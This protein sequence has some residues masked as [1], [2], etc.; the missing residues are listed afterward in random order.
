M[1]DDP[2]RQAHQRYMEARLKILDQQQRARDSLAAEE[3]RALM[4]S[5]RRLTEDYQPVSRELARRH[6]HEQ[7]LAASPRTTPADRAQFIVTNR[8]RF[9]VAQALGMREVARMI[10]SRASFAKALGRV[11]EYERATLNKR[12][13]REI[14][15]Q[16]EPI[17][18]T[19]QQRMEMLDREQEAERDRALGRYTLEA[20]DH[21][22]ALQYL[23]RDGLINALEAEPAPSREQSGLAP[24]FNEKGLYSPFFQKRSERIKVQMS[25]WRKAHME[26]ENDIERTR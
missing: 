24:S 11:H 22:A 25:D 15:Q 2:A 5:A 13:Q 7:R 1:N 9:S 17:Q 21:Q 8:Q 10:V 20:P 14:D 26:Q 4:S 3:R 6:G 12:V 18:Q 23:K 19:F 16:A